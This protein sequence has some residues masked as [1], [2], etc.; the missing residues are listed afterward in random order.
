MVFFFKKKKKIGVSNG[1]YC[2]QTTITLVSIFGSKNRYYTC[3]EFELVNILHFTLLAPWFHFCFSSIF[4]K[5]IKTR[6]IR[7]FEFQEAHLIQFNS[8]IYKKKKKKD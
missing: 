7:I 4:V 6:V 3:Q 8:Y 1:S 2:V 5:M